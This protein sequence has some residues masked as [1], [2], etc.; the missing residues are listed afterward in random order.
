MASCELHAVPAVVEDLAGMA[1]GSKRICLHL[2]VP[3]F[4][5]WGQNL[6]VCGAGMLANLAS[7]Q[8]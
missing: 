8:Q 2:R 4:T 1:L 6:V 7:T 3:Y 5:S